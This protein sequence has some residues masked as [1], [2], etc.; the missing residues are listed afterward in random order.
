MESS[1][2]FATVVPEKLYQVTNNHSFVDKS[3]INQ[4]LDLQSQPI[5]F[6]SPHRP[7]T[8]GSDEAI[9]KLANDLNSRRLMKIEEPF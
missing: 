6:W 1:L 9:K 7:N 8:S 2:S 5:P 3:K 4:K